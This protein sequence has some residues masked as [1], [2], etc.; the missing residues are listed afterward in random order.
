MKAL[1][2]GQCGD[3]QG[4]IDE[5]RTCRCGLVRAHWIDGRRGLAEF[6]VPNIGYRQFAYLLGLNNQVLAPA[7]QGELGMW[8]DFRERAEAATDAPGY[9]F[10]KTKAGSWAVVVRAGRTDDVTWYE[11]EGG[12]FETPDNELRKAQHGDH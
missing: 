3:I 10:D 5:W 2:C 9:I 8:Q 6:D 4:L 7:L 1:A 12:T 11:P